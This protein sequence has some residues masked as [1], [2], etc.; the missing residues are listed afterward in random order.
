MD[1]YVSM[2]AKLPKWIRWPFV[3]LAAAI[4]A[5]VV[6]FVAGILAKIVVFFDGGRGWGENFFQYLLIPGFSTY[7]S[8]VAGTVMAPKLRQGTS[9]LLSIVWVFAAG[10]LTFFSILSSTWASLITVASVCVGSGIAALQPYDVEESSAISSEA[11]PEPA[12]AD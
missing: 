6:W 9:L 12:Q 10:A 8:I 4:T 2:V 11:L 1:A 3:P 7:C 5:I